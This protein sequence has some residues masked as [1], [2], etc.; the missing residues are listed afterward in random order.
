ML[1]N[2]LQP[3]STLGLTITNM[4]FVDILNIDNAEWD[5]LHQVDVKIY[6]IIN[7]I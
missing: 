4:L 5:K 3:P 6:L 1:F 2:E 7:A